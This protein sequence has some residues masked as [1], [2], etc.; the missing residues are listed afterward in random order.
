M[1]NT[2]LKQSG[3]LAISVVDVFSTLTEGINTV[4]KR[5]ERPVD[6][7]ALYHPLTTIL[8]YTK[9]QK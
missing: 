1:T 3:Q 2:H 6:V 5:E 9:I 4:T 7:S 8:K